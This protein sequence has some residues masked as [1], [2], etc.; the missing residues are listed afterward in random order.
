MLF[1]ADESYTFIH[2]EFII[3]ERITLYFLIKKVKIKYI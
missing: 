3:F 1:I 2:Y